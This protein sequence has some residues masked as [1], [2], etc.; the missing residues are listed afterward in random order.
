MERWNPIYF[1]WTSKLYNLLT[2]FYKKPSLKSWGA[3][4]VYYYMFSIFMASGFVLP[5]R[6][7]AGKAIHFVNPVPKHWLALTIHDTGTRYPYIKVV[8]HCILFTPRFQLHFNACFTM[9]FLDVWILIHK[10]FF[11]FLTKIVC[12][13]ENSSRGAF[14]FIKFSFGKKFATFFPQIRT[15]TFEIT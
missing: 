8:V 12:V 4:S 1:K 9:I 2:F 6:K 10:T 5:L 15:F 3:E 11:L 14:P 7:S 13:G